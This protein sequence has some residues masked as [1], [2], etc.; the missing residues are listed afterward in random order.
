VAGLLWSGCTDP[1]L[2]NVTYS[3]ETIADCKGDLIC[4]KSHPDDAQGIC[5]AAGE[6][7]LPDTSVDV[8]GLDVVTEDTQEADGN[9][10]E[11]RGTDTVEPGDV[12]APEDTTLVEDTET[13]TVDPG[14]VEQP[15][16]CDVEEGVPGGL[17]DDENECTADQCLEGFCVH[18]IQVGNSCGDSEDLCI[19]S[20]CNDQGECVSQPVLCDDED[21]CTNDH[22]LDGICSHN[23]VNCDDGAV[24]NEDSCNEVTGCVHSYLEG[25]CFDDNECTADLCSGDA[26][27]SENGDGSSGCYWEDLDS[28]CD[29]GNACTDTDTC[30]GG[31]CVGESS[32][33]DD[34]SACTIDSCDEQ[35]CVYLDVDCNDG[36]FCN[37]DSCDA[38]TGCVH[39]DTPGFCFDDNEC[40]EDLCSGAAVSLGSSGCY[41]ENLAGDCDDDDACT[42]LDAC[43]DGSCAGT[44]V[45]CDDGIICTQNTCD[46]D[47]NCQ[48]P[49]TPNAAPCDDGDPCAGDQ[50]DGLG[51]CSPGNGDCDDQNECTVDSCEPDSG[52]IFIPIISEI[53]GTLPVFVP[54]FW[55]LSGDPSGDMSGAWSSLGDGMGSAPV[56]AEIVLVFDKT[57]QVMEEGPA[58]SVILSMSPLELDYDSSVSEVSLTWSLSEDGTRVLAQIPSVFLTEEGLLPSSHT[59]DLEV[60]LDFP[61][62][63]VPVAPDPLFLGFTTATYESSLFDYSGETEGISSDLK[64]L[65]VHASSSSLFLLGRTTGTGADGGDFVIRRVPFAGS[66]DAPSASPFTDVALVGDLIPTGLDVYD[67]AM[68]VSVDGTSEG[69]GWYVDEYDL[70][71]LNTRVPTGPTFSET[72]SS[73]VTGNVTDYTHVSSM[74]VYDGHYVFSKC[75]SDQ[76]AFKSPFFVDA[77]ELDVGTWGSWSSGEANES[78]HKGLRVA[79]KPQGESTTAYSIH[80]N[81]L[82]Q[83]YYDDGANNPPLIEFSSYLQGGFD[84][85]VDSQERVYVARSMGNWN[86]VGLAVYKKAPFGGDW[87]IEAEFLGIPMG[88]IALRETGG[89]THVYYG[90]VDGSGKIGLIKIQW[91]Q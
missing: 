15:V 80:G 1:D 16:E 26:V 37:V 69:N 78:I 64:A 56:G 33:C 14:D 32:S 48:Y 60:T 79:K 63:I 7:G 62:A 55:P 39:S 83:N 81:T 28:V 74:M 40:T 85:A 58:V 42:L 89:A 90:Q 3:C 49:N 75:A 20:V 13:D 41:W 87:S 50:C 82:R 10:V 61:G 73:D 71:G 88:R 22:C 54:G 6:V 84:I 53:C 18:E 76:D 8:A 11:D 19:P 67:D 36:A 44:A 38:V 25:F 43:V 23:Q 27:V 30:I 72:W 4:Q 31:S 66:F 52:C 77:E 57:L 45:E 46:V 2:S 51:V 21:A 91:I 17:C 24:C 47:G 5:V 86:E 9:V 70:G 35:G 12:Q 29:D 68:L 59:Y 34:G 65:A